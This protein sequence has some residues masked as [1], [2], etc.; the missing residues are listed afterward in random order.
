MQKNFTKIGLDISPE[1]LELL[2]K[3]RKIE[4]RSRANFMRTV[5]KKYAEKII[6]QEEQTSA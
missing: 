3:A 6:R 1:E 2:E 5:T 4:N